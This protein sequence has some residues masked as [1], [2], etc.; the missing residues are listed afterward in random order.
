MRRE[1]RNVFEEEDIYNEE[2]REKAVEED[3]YEDWQEAW[4]SGYDEA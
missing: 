4:M 1:D 2:T 3:E